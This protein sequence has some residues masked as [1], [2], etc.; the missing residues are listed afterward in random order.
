[1]SRYLLIFI[2][3]G[4]TLF[5]TAGCGGNTAIVAPEQAGPAG[6]QAVIDDASGYPAFPESSVDAPP[7]RR[8][9]DDDYQVN[10]DDFVHEYGPLNRNGDGNSHILISE[11]R[12]MAWAW[13]SVPGLTG[14]RPVSLT[15]DVEPAELVPG[16]GTDLPLYYWVGVSDFTNR[17]W[18]FFGDYTASETIT[19]NSAELCDRFVDAAG[20]L[21]FFV[22]VPPTTVPGDYFAV[23]VN[24]GT[25]TTA[26]GYLQNKPHNVLIETIHLGDPPPGHAPS[27]IHPLQYVNLGWEHVAPFGAWDEDNS[28]DTY[29]VH[30]R[31]TG[32]ADWELIGSVNAP[33]AVYCD[34]VDN[35]PGISD[36]LPCEWYHYSIQ[37][38]NEAGSTARYARSL[39]IPLAPPTELSA[40]D[41]DFEDKIVLT[42]T[43][44]DAATGYQVF[45]NNDFGLP[46]AELGDVDTWED[47]DIFPHIEYTYWVKS[48]KDGYLSDFSDS[49]TGHAS[50][51]LPP[52][53][54]PTD[55]SATDGDHADKVVLTWVKAENAIGYDVYRDDTSAPPVATLGDVD[56]WDDTAVIPGTVYTYW[57]RSRQ[58]EYS[59]DLSAH[60]NGYAGTLPDN[61]DLIHFPQE[62]YPDTDFLNIIHADPVVRRNP[63]GVFDIFGGTF[64]PEDEGAFHDILKTNGYDY[65]LELD[66]DGLWPR[67]AI[68][69][70]ADPADILEI[71]DGLPGIVN[72]SPNTH[73]LTV[74]V[75]TLTTQGNPGDPD[76]TYS[77]KV[78]NAS[79]DSLGCGTFIVHKT[80]SA[81]TV[82]TGTNWAINVWDRESLAIANR[83]Y[84]DFTLDGATISTTTPDVI[85][86]EFTGGWYFEPASY[87]GSGVGYDNMKALFKDTGS[88][89]VMESTIDVV[90]AGIN[91]A[92][93]VIAIHGVTSLDFHSLIPGWPGIFEPGKTYSVSLADRYTQEIDY[94]YPQTL[95]IT[96][97]NPNDL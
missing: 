82:A 24:T 60:D 50:T 46:V 96:G 37:A 20:T 30:R 64:V 34:P 61:P 2:L 3:V 12:R 33:T 25:V 76:E 7:A 16:D 71:G 89:A 53:D 62:F 97:P 52:L 29:E 72:L 85:W 48:V 80:G 1:M 43:K 42:W 9:S 28:A 8:V 41:G 93:T 35:D 77:Y 18:Q 92:G 78:F 15:L 56:T 5:L 45:R 17:G 87:S 36:P 69:Q 59:S 58:V 11:H 27:A 90:I 21:H 88:A 51:L 57:V 74:D 23:Q 38:V 94:T 54:P 79:G 19:I 68:A 55:I 32:T 40:T 31:L 39:L 26:P 14:D 10:G 63:Q 73:R 66:D 65:T 67:V 70:T 22:L 86:F 44:A 91:P 75:V 13:Y 4:I 47:T 95:F 49:D 81:Q 83:Q 6:N 84:T